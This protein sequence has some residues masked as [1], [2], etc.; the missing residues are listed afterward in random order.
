MNK[1]LHD[2]PPPRELSNDFKFGRAVCKCIHASPVRIALPDGTVMHFEV[3]VIGLTVPVL[4]GLDV[5]R[6]YAI[7]LD[8]GTGHV[9]AATGA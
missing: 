1:L 5:L 2:R 4:L 9:T 8:F 3:A 6:K 7:V